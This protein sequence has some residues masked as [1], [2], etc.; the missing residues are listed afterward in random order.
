M[1]T[2]IGVV[3]GKILDFLEKED[4]ITVPLLL[5]KT[6]KNIGADENMVYM[7][8]GWLIRK[9]YVILDKKDLKRTVHLTNSR[10][11]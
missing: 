6:R 3:A 8:L 11:E 9:G 4:G 7:S 5:S 2:R 1:I 10:S